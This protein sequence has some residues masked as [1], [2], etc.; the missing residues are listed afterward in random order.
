VTRLE[1]IRAQLE[2]GSASLQSD[3]RWLLARVDALEAALR[4]ALPL[5]ESRIEL[6]ANVY[7]Q[8][9]LYR[10]QA[11]HALRALDEEAS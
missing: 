7:P 3:Q 10:E 2:E 9:I 4:W 11:R 6:D 5:A 1:K 8:M